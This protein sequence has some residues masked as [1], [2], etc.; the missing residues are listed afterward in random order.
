MA[1]TY[2]WL[3]ADPAVA[4][5]TGGYFD[6]PNVPVKA[7]KNAYNRETQKR[8]WEVSAELVKVHR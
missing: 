5:I 2:V 8:L 1:E 3:A 7:N 6:A 4:N